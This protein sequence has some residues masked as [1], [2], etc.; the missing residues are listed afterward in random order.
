MKPVPLREKGII[1][2]TE[3]YLLKWYYEDGTL[4]DDGYENK[5]ISFD[6]DYNA[7][8]GDKPLIGKYF[9]DED[10]EVEQTH[11]FATD[12][13]SAV[14]YW[15]RYKGLK[16]RERLRKEQPDVYE[17]RQKYISECPMEEGENQ[18]YNEWLFRFTFGDVIE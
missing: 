5:P 1:Y 9:D 8:D 2:D 16:G 14:D 11:F 18:D 7:F 15:L 4:Y 6:G 10:N 17:L 3:K 12:V 13:Q